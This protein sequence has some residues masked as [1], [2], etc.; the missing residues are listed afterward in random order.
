L[1]TKGLRILLVFVTAITYKIFIIL[2]IRIIVSIVFEP[3]SNPTVIDRSS[4]QTESMDY[5]VNY[6]IEQRNQSILTIHF[7][8]IPPGLNEDQKQIWIDIISQRN[9]IRA[10]E[11]GKIWCLIHLSKKMVDDIESIVKF[12]IENYYNILNN[13]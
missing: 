3:P 6:V 2:C 7:K 4:I 9:S 12:C 13:A 11:V 1:I 8:T 5:K 10:I